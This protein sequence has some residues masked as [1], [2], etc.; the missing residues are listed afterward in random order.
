MARTTVSA[1]IF[2]EAIKS[3]S[4]EIVVKNAYLAQKGDANLNNYIYNDLYVTAAKKLLTKYSLSFLNASLDQIDQLKSQIAYWESQLTK[5]Q[6]GERVNNMPRPTIEESI[7][8]Y[9]ERI[10]EAEEQIETVISINGTADES[11]RDAMRTI[12]NFTEYNDYYRM[13]DGHPSLNSDDTARV[14]VYNED[15]QEMLPIDEQPYGE[16]NRWLLSSDGVKFLS[17]HKNEEK[18]KY[19][20]YMTSKRIRP[21]IARIA[22]RFE[23]LYCPVSDPQ[24]LSEDFMQIYDRSLNYIIRVYYSEAYRRTEAE[25]Y[26]GF[27]G[28]MILFMTIAEMHYKYLD[29]DISREFYDLD[30]LK[31][32]YEAYG[33]PFYDIIPLKYHKKIVKNINRLICRK[34]SNQVFFDLCDI[35][36]YDI[37]GIYQYYL[38]KE[39]RMDGSGDPVVQWKTTDGKEVT[40]DEDGNPTNLPLDIHGN[41]V[42]ELNPQGMYDIYFVR[43]NINSDRYTQ[44]IDPNNKVSY[45]SIVSNDS[46]WF[47]FDPDTISTIYN[48]EY[49]YIETKYI[50]VQLMFNMTDLLWESS[51]FMGMLR[52]NRSKIDGS[53]FMISHDRLGTN[54]PLFDMLIYIITL[55]C[56]KRGYT[57]EIR[58]LFYK[59]DENGNYLD[60]NG[61]IT[62]NPDEYVETPTKIAR[63][64][65]FNFKGLLTGSAAI[66]DAFNQ[67][68]SHREKTM[69]GLH[70]KK[71]FNEGETFNQMDLDIGNDFFH[72]DDIQDWIHKNEGFVQSED[73]RNLVA[74]LF[75]AKSTS[76]K[77]A[78]TAY[79]ENLDI[80]NMEDISRAFKAMKNMKLDID[81]LLYNT[82]D[83]E[84]YNAL[85][86]L[87]RL[88]YTTEIVTEVFED[89]L[90]GELPVTYY[91]LLD[92]LNPQLATRA[93]DVGVNIDIDDELDYCLVQLQN[94]CDELK[95]MIYIDQVDID[96]ITEYLYKMLMFFKSAKVDLT[97]FNVVFYISDRSENCLKFIERLYEIKSTVWLDDT[98]QD[99]YDQVEKICNEVQIHDRDF[100]FQFTMEAMND[101]GSKK[102]HIDDGWELN[103]LSR[104][105]PV[106][107]TEDNPLDVDSLTKSETMSYVAQYITGAALPEELTDPTTVCR[108]YQIQNELQDDMSVKQTIYKLPRK[109]QRVYKDGVWSPFT[110]TDMKASLYMTDRIGE[111]RTPIVSKI[112]YPIFDKFGNLGLYDFPKRI[113]V[114]KKEK[115]GL[116]FEDRLTKI[117][118]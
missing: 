75:A 20:Q 60:A 58:G 108:P 96:I 102:I 52:D 48:N 68:I 18:Y 25:L 14:L 47:Q 111:K 28:M 39:R 45:D 6:N 32:V 109:Y 71:D 66:K 44:I 35:F 85:K 92:S 74:R 110:S 40:Y 17:E 77:E 80:T 46:Y 42:W 116:F 64:L 12:A 53:A 84:E 78:E 91:D 88:L 24:I 55:I 115:D 61:N 8:F 72:G 54:V 36:D 33:V 15:Y 114:N 22:G 37:L 2:N 69:Q 86:D 117:T 19:L 38:F 101:L 50:G 70:I 99:L 5:L 105:I 31:I 79:F 89:A 59:V 67:A 93:D 73:G 1:R 95:Y 29:A 118:G 98:F 56:K 23:I 65:G 9:E 83:R 104:Y 34:G 11:S 106:Y 90:T 103:I 21:F 57:G 87:Q 76:T 113:Y 10:V 16:R 97:D 112:A 41:P 94:L 51:Y 43:A 3:I 27:I 7:E 49:N 62:T 82:H 107:T 4:R 30:S 100:V 81:T 13:L 63:I 26:E